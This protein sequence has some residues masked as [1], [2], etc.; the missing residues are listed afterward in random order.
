M[1]ELSITENLLHTCLEE[2]EK[3]NLSKISMIRV[4]TG[5]F[6]GIVPECIQTYL[7]MLSE[8]TAAEGAKIS[9][10]T[11][12]AEVTCLDCGHV[13]RTERA[14]CKCPACGSIELKVSGGGEFIIESI[15]GESF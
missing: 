5:L 12:P 6:S 14:V 4:K 13:I 2:A 7:D 1:H 9:S 11:V 3:N 8:G 15:E 10:E